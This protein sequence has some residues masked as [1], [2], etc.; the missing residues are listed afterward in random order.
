LCGLR[1]VRYRPAQ[2]V[3]MAADEEISLHDSSPMNEKP[4]HRPAFVF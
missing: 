4:D 2:A 1:I 3:L